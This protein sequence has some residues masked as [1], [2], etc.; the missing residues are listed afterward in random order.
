M[1]KLMVSCSIVISLFLGCTTTP[2][3]TPEQL[4]TADYGALPSNAETL[5]HSVVAPRLID[6]NSATYVLSSPK[7]GTNT[8]SGERVYGW[9][10][11]GTINSKNRFG[12]YVGPR[13]VFALI[14][15]DKIAVLLFEGITIP[16]SFKLGLVS[17]VMSQ[18]HSSE[19][20]CRD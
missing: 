11:C 9:K 14:K 5:I 1:K 12:G 3:P 18:S 8:M 17:G 13:P 19:N 2:R 16:D 4:S 20:F 10:V 15:D 7:K 6:P